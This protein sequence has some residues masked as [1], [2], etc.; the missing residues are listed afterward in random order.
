MVLV[1]MC[2]TRGHTRQNDEASRTPFE[3]QFKWF[4]TKQHVFVEVFFEHGFSTIFGWPQRSSEGFSFEKELFFHFRTNPQKNVKRR[5]FRDPGWEH[6]SLKVVYGTVP[7]FK[8]ENTWYEGPAPPSASSRDVRLRRP[9]G[10]IWRGKLKAGS[11]K[12]TISD[13]TLGSR[14]GH[15]TFK[16]KTIWKPIF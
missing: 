4:L 6:L 14:A 16:A 1:P 2:R 3:V 8:N 12:H 13:H 7:K 15:L 10:T 5:Q 9:D 11:K